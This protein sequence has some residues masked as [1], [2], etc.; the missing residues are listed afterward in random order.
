MVETMQRIVLASVPEGMP[1]ESD[2]AFEDVPIPECPD[3]G[4]LVHTRWLSVDPYLRGRMTGIRTYIDPIHVG[5]A[6]ESGSIG[7]VLVSDHPMFHP[8]DMVV[9]TWGW[10][11]FAALSGKGLLKI[12]PAIAPVTT[13][14]G[15]LGMPGMT[16]YFG[17]LE[18]CAPKPGETVVVSG[19]A[20]AVGSAVGQIAKILGC[21]VVGIA[22]SAEKCE[23]LRTLK[24][25]GVLNYRTDTPYG[26]KLAKLC[27]D[28]IDCYFDNVGG[29]MADAVL[30][31]MNTN[32]RV[33]VC[34]QISVYNDR[35][36]DIGPRPFAQILMKQLRVEGFIV[37][38]WLNR[39]Q[40][41]Q[42]RMAGWLRDGKLT[43]RET[44]YGGLKSAPHAF[45]GLFH[46]D[47][48]GKAL[49]KL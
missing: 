39:W 48:L 6:M 5:Q 33:S 34:G 23:Y 11:E 44:V 42:A 30:A 36:R 27:P 46:G 18:I 7:E 13:A 43:Y 49:V 10:Q 20:G 9:G 12:D 2:F 37:T 4:L 8:G 17:L 25:D 3:G 45:I 35:S 40:E 15:V 29:E 16:A 41:G 31:R 14:L 47:N 26:E 1:A 19:A 28:G 24:F 32:G 21:H 22:G 38:R